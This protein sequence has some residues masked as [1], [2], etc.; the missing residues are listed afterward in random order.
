MT[1]MVCIFACIYAYIHICIYIHLFYVY[2][3]M[4]IYIYIYIYM[5]T[6]LSLSRTHAGGTHQRSLVTTPGSREFLRARALSLSLACSFA[7]SRRILFSRYSLAT[8]LMSGKLIGWEST[9]IIIKNIKG[10][11]LW[12]S[13]GKSCVMTGNLTTSFQVLATVRSQIPLSRH[14][15]F[16]LLF[17]RV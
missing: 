2:M 11:V 9:F 5:L 7:R 17:F 3:Y 15:P 14:V 6:W 12:V 16:P 4:Y 1:Q 8:G 10:F 13:I